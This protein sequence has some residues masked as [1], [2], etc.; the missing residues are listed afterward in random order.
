[1]LGDLKNESWGTSHNLETVE[2]WWK[3]LIELDV[4]DGS[5]DSDNAS[6]SISSG[7]FG[8]NLGSGGSLLSSNSG[9]NSLLGIDRSRAETNCRNNFLIYT[10]LN[11]TYWKRLEERTSERYFAEDGKPNG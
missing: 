11:E 1:M 8:R 10:H 6:G 4:N 3:V 7:S 2:D 5:D 9:V